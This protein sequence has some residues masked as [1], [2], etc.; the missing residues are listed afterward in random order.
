MLYFGFFGLFGLSILT[1]FLVRWYSL[2]HAILDMPNERSSH[3]LPTPRG[4]G[5]G[6][7]LSFYVGLILL[8]HFGLLQENIGLAL[9]GGFIIV[10]IGWMDDIYSLPARWRA[11]FHFIAALWALYWLQGFPSLNMGMT[12][13]HLSWF[14]FFL[15]TLGIVWSIN[16]YNFMDGIDGLAGSEAIFV[17]LS[18]GILL[19]LVGSHLALICFLL[20]PA[21]LGFLIWNWPPA[22]I[23]MGD[24]GSGF[25][26]FIFA[27]LA[28]ASENQHAL[29]IIIWIILLAVFIFDATF[30]LI[31]RIK[32][33][34]PLYMAHRDHAYQ[35]ITH[36]GYRH[37]TVV[38]FI[39]LFN[40]FI[41]LPIAMIAFKWPVTLLPCLGLA[42]LVVLMSSRVVEGSPGIS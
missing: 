31:S 24:V 10:I 37:Q 23:F 14:G 21:T 25:L 42:I 16:L 3:T 32:R 41:L 19:F 8:F 13:L 7:V 39:L 18:A 15:A 5:L 27:V 9:L 38:I 26:G 28:I 34:Q 12:L 22:K 35:R 40:I 33:R 29:P 2:H 1:V 6:L 30:T 36:K 4:G 11:P 17:S 20:L